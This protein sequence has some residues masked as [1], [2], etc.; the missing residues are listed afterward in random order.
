[1][2]SHRIIIHV[3]L[4]HRRIVLRGRWPEKA[5]YKC[6]FS[7]IQLE[8]HEEGFPTAML[9]LPR[10]APTSRDSLTILGHP[11]GPPLKYTASLDEGFVLMSNLPDGE[12]RALA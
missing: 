4:L 5:R 8:R 7:I 10:K 11:H 9:N 12:K 1:M 3:H 2:P 6:D